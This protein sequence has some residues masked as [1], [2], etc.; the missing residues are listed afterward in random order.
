WGKT[1]NKV[2]FKATMQQRQDVNKKMELR[3]GYRR[4][5]RSHKRYRP[6]RFNNR[7]SSKRFGRLPPTIKQKKQAILRV[8]KKLSKYIRFDKIV[9]EDVAI[10]IRVLTEGRKLYE[11]QY[12]HSNRLDENLR[13]A[14]LMRDEYTC[15]MCGAEDTV[16]QA[17]HIIPTRDSG[18]DSIHNLITL[19]LDC[20]DKVT[21]NE[22]EYKDQFLDIISGREFS[23]IPAM[24]VMQGKTYLREELAK[25]ANLEVTTGGDT[26][27]SRIDYEISKSHSNDAIC[28]TGL[29]PVNMVKI[30]EWLIKPLRKK[31]KN[32]TM[33]LKGF[34]HR[35]IVRYTKRDG[36]T[37]IGQITA[38]RVKN[39]K[40]NSKVCNFR[41]FEGETFRG[42]GLKNLELISRAKGLMFI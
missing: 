26:A 33:S 16:L 35:D 41:T 36:T 14:T 6:K 3:S 25:I 32:R 13:K 1:K 12:Q 4:Y 10:D 38:L 21:D 24:H 23:L 29:L 15:Q 27:N 9:L 22:Y 40:Y 31:K 28:V 11:W 30:K 34:K 5:R 39:D 19:C 7:S 2:L 42:Y 8:V 18:P 17:H 20:H 37:Y